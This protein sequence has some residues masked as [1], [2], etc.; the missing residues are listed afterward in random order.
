MVPLTGLEPVRYCYQRI[1]SPLCL[2]IPPQGHISDIKQV[3]EPT[4]V[5][6][7]LSVFYRS[8]PE[9]STLFY[10]IGSG[11]LESNQDSEG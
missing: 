9:L 7:K 11:T 6:Y 4:H 3:L 5:F 2:P 1:L 10:V 8:D